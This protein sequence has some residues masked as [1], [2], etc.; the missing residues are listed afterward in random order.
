MVV[1]AG[2]T[3]LT[4]ATMLKSAGRS[5]VI[6]EA[7]DRVGGRLL[8]ETV[9]GTRVEQ[10]GQWLSA[11]QDQLL[12]LIEDLGLATFPRYRNGENVYIGHDGVRR[13]YS[14]DA[15]P[16]SAHTTTQLHRVGSA[17]DALARQ[18]NPEAPW[19][20][21]DAEELD[22]VSFASWLAEQTD[23]VEALNLAGL[24]VGPAM[25]A[26]PNSA[27]SL[28]TAALLTS[29]VGGFSHLA[30][31]NVVLDLRVCGGLSQVADRLA[32]R[33]AG[34]LVL[35]SP[36]TRIEWSEDGATVICGRASY[37]ARSV[38][39]TM[40]PP[41]VASIDFLPPLAEPQCELRARQHMGQV[42]KVSAQYDEPFWRHR[43]LSGT[44]FSPYQ[45]VHE[46]YD[47]CNDDLPDGSG[48]L[49]GF[50]AGENA[51]RA[52]RSNPE[53][54]RAAVLASLSAYFGEQ[55]LR[56]SCYVE[57][58]WLADPFAGGAYGSS[59]E[60]G[61]LTRHGPLMREP[62]GP[63][64]FGSADLAGYGYLHVDGAVRVGRMLGARL[65]AKAQWS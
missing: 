9:N 29:S 50:I 17:L 7:R 46:V 22:A 57:S 55:A 6:V 65:A 8:T 20:H 16:L 44:A 27:F 1:G 40:P 26:R 13:T 25:I 31:E 32:A 14:G 11:G 36:V 53:H 43:N 61:A 42:I 39:L 24:Y 60:V 30:D 41:L 4:A 48:I 35:N 49:V 12:R 56:T 45:L 37:W 64:H 23:D 21:P 54:R 33:L 18:L 59:F 47:N 15:L 2:V 3:G 62:V 58:P 19:E 5:V 38:L 34:N 28:L 10:G 63:L 51:T 52:A